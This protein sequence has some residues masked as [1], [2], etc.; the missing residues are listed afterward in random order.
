MKHKPYKHIQDLIN[1]L[2]KD[3]AK[4]IKYAGIGSYK[5]LGFTILSML[6]SCQTHL[7]SLENQGSK[8]EEEIRIDI[9]N[10]LEL[11]K[12]LLPHLEFE[13]LDKVLVED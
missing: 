1:E 4:H 13:F 6:N 3:H 9:Y 8:E 5:H 2:K 12:K 7:F 10:L 11:I